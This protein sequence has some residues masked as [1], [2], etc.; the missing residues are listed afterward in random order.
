MQRVLTCRFFMTIQR[1]VC[2]VYA[3][4]CVL[5]ANGSVRC[6]D[7]SLSLALRVHMWVDGVVVRPRARAPPTRNVPRMVQDSSARIV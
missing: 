3:R 6:M 7:L 2:R 5:S 4:R 1:R